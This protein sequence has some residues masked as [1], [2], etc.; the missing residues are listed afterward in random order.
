MKN[1]TILSVFKTTTALLAIIGL[2]GLFGYSYNQY[3]FSETV[4]KNQK[5]EIEMLVL[6]LKKSKLDLEKNIS[7]NTSCD[8]ELIKERQKVIDLLAKIKNTPVDALVITKY[9][10]EVQR[11]KQFVLYLQQEKAKL[12]KSSQIY[13]AQRD[14][15]LLALGDS[16]KSNDTLVTLNKHLK[17]VA[18]NTCEITLTNLQTQTMKEDKYGELT[19]TDKAKKVSTLKITFMMVII[20]NSQRPCKKSY[21]VQVIDGENNVLGENKEK[22]YGDSILNYSY[23]F[24]VQFPSESSNVESEIKIEN[25]KKGI[26]FVNVFDKGKLSNK[27]SFTLR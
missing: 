3:Q 15:T 23:I 24:N 8:D 2:F 9:K 16:K 19:I 22:K 12:L 18:K 1:T 17:E 26:Y 20:G 25:A 4:K 5:A 11:L 14:S 13:K 6:D 27:T 10:K 21:Y 7:E